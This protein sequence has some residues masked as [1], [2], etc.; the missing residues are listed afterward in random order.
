MDKLI[1]RPE[2]V[3]R[4]KAVQDRIGCGNSKFYELLKAGEFPPGIRIG[5]R[6]VGWRESQ[7]EAWIASRPLVDLRKS[8]R[9]QF[10]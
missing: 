10:A 8:H 7:V 2:R 5:S 3:L 4:A 1:H 9:E 6:S